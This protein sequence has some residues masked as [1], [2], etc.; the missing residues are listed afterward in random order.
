MK[1]KIIFEFETSKD[2]IMVRAKTKGKVF[3]AHVLAAKQFIED[4]IKESKKNENRRK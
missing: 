3:D 1:S 4:R 2:G